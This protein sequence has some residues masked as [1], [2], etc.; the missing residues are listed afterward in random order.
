MHGRY[1]TAEWSLATDAERPPWTG[2][3][4]RPARV[5]HHYFH[6]ST[7]R[8]LAGARTREHEIPGLIELGYWHKLI[9]RSLRRSLKYRTEATPEPDAKA[10]PAQR[11]GNHA[12]RDR[13][14]SLRGRC[15]L[16]FRD[17]IFGRVEIGASRQFQLVETGRSPA[18]ARSAQFA[19]VALPMFL[20]ALAKRAVR[21]DS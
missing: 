10:E 2:S 21:A 8:S 5:V 12:L 17:R 7:R 14:T 1:P 20:N 19:P 4:E 3:A 18:A 13:D 16:Q 15:E 9:A 6:A 11:R